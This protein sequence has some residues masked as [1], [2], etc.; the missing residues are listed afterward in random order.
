MTATVGLR[1]VRNTIRFSIAAAEQRNLIV[2]DKGRETE[3]DQARIEAIRMSLA[4]ST[5][6]WERVKDDPEAR[7]AK[8]EVR[9]AWFEIV[10]L[11]QD[12]S[13]DEIKPL[14]AKAKQLLDA[15]AKA[16]G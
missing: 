1:T 6:E 13:N 5:A 11:Y 14:V 16:G 2:I 9:A 8:R 10:V 3:M 12:E 7:V 15:N 4:K